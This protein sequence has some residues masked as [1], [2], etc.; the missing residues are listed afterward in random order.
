[1]SLTTGLIHPGDKFLNV[2]PTRAFNATQIGAERFRINESY[3]A[4]EVV[5]G[6][7]GVNAFIYVIRRN[8][9]ANQ[10]ID[11]S[12][13]P[14]NPLFANIPFTQIS[15]ADKNINAFNNITSSDWNRLSLAS[16]STGYNNVELIRN[17]VANDFGSVILK[18]PISNNWTT[19]TIRAQT[20]ITGNTGVLYTGLITDPTIINTATNHFNTSGLFRWYYA[21]FN[22]NGFKKVTNG[23][24]SFN[25]FDT[26]A[27]DETGRLNS[28]AITFQRETPTSESIRVF[29]SLNGATY[30]SAYQANALPITGESYLM[31]GAFFY[32]GSATSCM[33]VG[34]ISYA[35]TK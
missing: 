14:A 18:K 19:L 6:G 17:G 10:E 24:E 25:P 27:G 35:I 5:W 22:S 16:F 21:D 3:T 23:V 32:A 4:G 29:G 26:L 28:S 8:I 1:M 7:T 13:N 20:S 31:F 34:N 33:N 30:T 11:W 9:T 12:F 15:T 2:E